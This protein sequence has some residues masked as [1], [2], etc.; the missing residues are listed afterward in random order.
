MEKIEEVIEYPNF[1]D[2]LRDFLN[3]IDALNETL[4]MVM[5][6]VSLKD[7]QRVKQLDKFIKTHDLS[8]EL[9]KIEDTTEKKQENSKEEEIISLEIGNFIQFEELQKNAEISR[10]AFKVIPRSLF[11]SLISQFDAFIGKLIRIIFEL[12]PEKLNSSDKTLSY[13][14]LAGF[15]NIN[16]AKEYIIEK[17]IET[18]LR[19]SHT[20]HFE[21][22]EKKLG[23]PL[24]NK[25]PIWSTFIEITERRNLF[26]HSDGVV[27]NQYIYNCKKNNVTNCEKV[28]ITDLLDVTPEYFQD[29]YECIFELSVKLTHVVWRKLLPDDLENADTELNDIC[30]DLIISEEFKLADILLEFATDILP[31]HHNEVSKNVF[32][33]NR[34]LS[35][36]LAKDID[37]SRKMLSDKDWSA[38]NNSFKLAVKVLNEEY[39]EAYELMKQIGD[40][41]EVPK[42]AYQ[43]WPLFR[44]IRSEEDFRKIYSEIFK[45]DYKII[46][47]PSRRTLML[48][49]DSENKAQ[50]TA[51]AI[52][53]KVLS[54]KKK[55]N[56]SNKN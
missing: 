19:E 42:H 10:V 50:P 34:A 35:K 6:L 18:V 9:K 23:I 36:Y 33:I 24:R 2:I 43:K 51:K 54:G 26:S 44:K 27:S 49:E 55:V 31:K 39:D 56:A 48:L 53:N 5:A 25:L 30:Y 14:Q 1:S 21:W 7:K 13:S 15:Q 46:E 38:T 3:E 40:N 22:L 16:D 29:S 47:R 41:S 52:P 37:S 28:K 12:Y 45:E 11:V 4:P 20:Y 8:K 32:I 17:E